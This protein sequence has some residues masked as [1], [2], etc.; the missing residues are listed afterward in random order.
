MKQVWN[1]WNTSVHQRNY[2]LVPLLIG[3]L[4]FNARS[5]LAT[6][7]VNHASVTLISSSAHTDSSLKDSTDREAFRQYQTA[8]WINPDTR[9]QVLY[10]FLEM[11]LTGEQ[12]EGQLPSCGESSHFHILGLQL[13]NQYIRSKRDDDAV[14]VYRLLDQ[15]CPNSFEVHF[16]WGQ[17]EAKVG[18]LERSIVLLKSATQIQPLDSSGAPSRTWSEFQKVYLA[19]AFYVLGETYEKA[20][21][22]RKAIDA[23]EE[24]AATYP[25]KTASPW[26]Y[27]LLG[28][29]YEDDQRLDEA[30]WAFEQALELRPTFIDAQ[31]FLDR[32]PAPGQSGPC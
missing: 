21:Q 25:P 1:V 4:I 16:Y 29:L 9:E 19:K 11:K 7:I 27:Y 32:L 6:A 23:L 14:A 2:V 15:A 10:R 24:S 3:A 12:S 17:M 13:A 22:S 8:A 18:R 20:G 30:R 26:M 31:Q 5:L 28:T